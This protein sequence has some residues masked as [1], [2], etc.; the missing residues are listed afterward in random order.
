MKRPTTLS[1]EKLNARHI[2]SFAKNFFIFKAAR[3][4]W[5]NWFG[6]EME[7]GSPGIIAKVPFANLLRRFDS[8]R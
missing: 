7:F 3:I 6:A 1:R 8:F 2:S 4:G 5:G